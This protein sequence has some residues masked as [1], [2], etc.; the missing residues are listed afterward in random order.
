MKVIRD[1]IHGYIEL[2]P[3]TL[4]IIDS[5]QMQRL[6]RLSQLG[7]S[8]LVYPGANHSR[9]EH[10][11]GVMHLATM[12]TGKIDT[13][14]EDEKEELRVAALL[15][16]VG[17]GPYSHV[18]ENL[19]KLYTR[20]HHEDVRE[21]LKKGELGEILSDNGLNPATIEDH[22][23]GKTDMGKILN[24]EI[25]VDR[26]DYLVRDS[27]YTGV[28]FGL[29]DHVRLIN[30]MKFY[31]NNL[32]VNSGGVKAAESLLV[33]RFLMHP[34]VYYHHVSRIAETMFTRAVDDLIQKKSLNPFDL[35]KMDDSGL[36]EMIR[37]DEGYAGELAQRLDNRK[38]YK[39]ALYVGFDEVGEGV[40]KHRKNIKRV[41]A[42]IAEEVGIEPES[43][44]IDI[45]RNPEIAE[46]KA[47][48]KVKNRMLRLDEA[49]HVVATLEQAHR[50]NWKMGVY[51]PTEYR[52]A[53]GKAAK[54]F[55]EVKRTT[56][57]FRLTEIE[58]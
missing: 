10:C 31:E 57:Q 9:F 28:A 1:P 36:L 16:D 20:Q 55:F 50:D 34:S 15:H 13:V 38:L 41:E 37:N 19:T 29:V 47:L 24:S 17:H 3:L 4:S 52:E 11:L 48:V 32:V 26:M 42:E 14:T 12:L 43:V 40:L 44:L 7:L 46:M 45:P 22:I 18:T 23:Q 53:V 35:R 30:E 21:I 56:K 54:N 27:H 49:S 39:R 2:D 33:S 25:D 58:E 8:N 51:T 6:R 5:P